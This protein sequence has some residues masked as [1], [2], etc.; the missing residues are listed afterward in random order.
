[1]R[2]VSSFHHFLKILHP[3]GQEAKKIFKKYRI[4]P[5]T[6]ITTSPHHHNITSSHLHIILHPSS[7]I[8]HLTIFKKICGIY[9]I[10]ERPKNIHKK[11]LREVSSF[12]H[13]LMILHPLGQEAKKIFKKYR[14]YHPILPFSNSLIPQNT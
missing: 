6:S 12:H 14:I 9:E 1:M 13:F 7:L 5:P 4:H 10:S 2:E 8:L 3:L 11:N